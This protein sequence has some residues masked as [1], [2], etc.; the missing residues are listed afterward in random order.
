VEEL[1]GRQML[2]ASA[3]ATVTGV[4]VPTLIN[5]GRV[6]S[7]GSVKPGN[8]PAS[9]GPYTPSQV[10]TAYGV[11]LI[12]FNGIVGNGAG[13][14]IAIVDAYNDPNIVS[15]TA[16]FNTRF[17]LPKFNQ[18]GG[19]TFQVLNQTGGTTLPANTNTTIGD[20]D[21][22]ESL[23][24]QWAH[25]MAP[26][27]NIILFESNTNN[28]PDMDAA[29]VTAANWPGV[30]VVS[31]SWGEGEFSGETSEDQYFQTP[32]GHE[33]V[34]FLASAGDSGSPAGY[35][36]YSPYV[37]AVGGKQRNVHLGKRLVRRRWRHQHA[38]IAS[39]L[40]GWAQR[41]QRY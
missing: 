27:A 40:S 9:S 3:T 6:A 36:S 14:T 1:E 39:Q 25:S 18:T 10:T 4:A 21:L 35:L 34:T 13:Q 20:W 5:L 8:S 22:E 33:G 41:H 26:Q 2:A 29:E 11:N 37:V 38:R 28:D 7:P 12:N 24:V 16:T 23:D 31:N 30:S 32:T 17:G 19:P 15:D